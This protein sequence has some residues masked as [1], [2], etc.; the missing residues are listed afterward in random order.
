MTWIRTVGVEDAAGHLARIYRH[1]NRVADAVHVEL[2]PEM[3][4]YP[5]GSR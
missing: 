3:P 5:D 4:S 2:E 1:T